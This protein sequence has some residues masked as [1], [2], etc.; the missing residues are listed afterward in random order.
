[1]DLGV[2]LCSHFASFSKDIKQIMSL[3]TNTLVILKTTVVSQKAFLST[4]E[5]GRLFLAASGLVSSCE[6]IG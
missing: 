1:M 2:Q 3:L 5:V 4:Q 6:Q